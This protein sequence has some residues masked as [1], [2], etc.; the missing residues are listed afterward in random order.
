MIDFFLFFT[1]FYTVTIKPQQLNQ[2]KIMQDPNGKNK[3]NIASNRAIVAVVHEKAKVD[4]PN[5][6]KN[7]LKKS[8]MDQIPPPTEPVPIKP[9]KPQLIV[10]MDHVKDH[11]VTKP[12]SST[13]VRS[14][15]QQIRQAKQSAPCKQFEYAEIQKKRKEVLLEKIRVEEKKQLKFDFHAKPAPNFRKGPVVQVKPKASLVKQQSLPQMPV[16]KQPSYHS[17]DVIVPSCGDPE[18]LRLVEENLKR[19]ASKYETKPFQFKAK[20]AK[21]LEK[22]P[23]VPKIVHV[24]SI[25]PKPFALK[26][27][28]RLL[29][30]SEFDKKL[31]ET[32]S[33]RKKQEDIRR[34][35]QDFEER[36][37]MRQK[38]EFRARANPFRP[39]H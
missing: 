19:L 4:K 12:T 30:R 39:G 27:S 32:I 31:H 29:Q 37:I 18:R 6:L 13:S 14:H 17:K 25:E 20:P 21:V 8:V 5:I 11:I 23:F 33:L 7:I 34:R 9:S 3:E 28:D 24:N 35:Q 26:L 10:K 22:K 38:T 1:L 15:L 2:P 36:K 16:T